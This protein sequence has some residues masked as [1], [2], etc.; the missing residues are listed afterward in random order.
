[1]DIIKEVDKFENPLLSNGIKSDEKFD[2]IKFKALCKE[3]LD[4]EENN[5]T[6]FKPFPIEQ[7]IVDESKNDCPHINKPLE[8]S[9]LKDDDKDINDIPTKEP[10]NCN[11]KNDH[12]SSNLK[13]YIF[14]V[15]ITLSAV[16]LF[17]I[18]ILIL[19]RK[20]YEFIF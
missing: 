2:N 11:D 20:S 10:S 9:I 13:I 18:T 3:F 5:E 17:V 14:V 16:G 15:V 7:T 6:S 1:M 19:K 4:S 8:S 12:D